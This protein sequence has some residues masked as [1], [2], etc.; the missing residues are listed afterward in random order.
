MKS[1]QGSEFGGT[2]ARKSSLRQEMK[3]F[4]DL[5]EFQRK[6]QRVKR[7]PGKSPKTDSRPIG[8]RLTRQRNKSRSVPQKVRRVVGAAG[9]TMRAVLDLADPIPAARAE[10]KGQGRVVDFYKIFAVSFATI[11]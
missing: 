6:E 7:K 8:A 11:A 2:N 10:E 4:A 9:E 5:L 3:R 1:I